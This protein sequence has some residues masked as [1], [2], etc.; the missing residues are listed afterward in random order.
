MICLETKLDTPSAGAQSSCWG[1][2]PSLALH[3]L[4][5]GCST[6]YACNITLSLQATHIA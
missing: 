5:Q 1:A 4:P 2:G 6:D 3:Q